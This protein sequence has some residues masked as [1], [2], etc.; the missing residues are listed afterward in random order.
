MLPRGAGRALLAVVLLSLPCARAAADTVAPSDLDA[1]LRVRDQLLLRR[2]KGRVRPQVAGPGEAPP[3]AASF[4]VAAGTLRTEEG[5]LNDPYTG[6]DVLRGRVVFEPGPACPACRSL[7][8]VQVARVEA[9]LGRDLDWTSGQENRNL[10]RTR[11]D[12][13]RGVVEGWFVDHDALRC[14]PGAPCSP[15]FRD[16]WPNPDESADGASAPPPAT[17]ASLVDYPF[18]WQSFERISLESCVRCADTGRFLG[19]VQWGAT[20]PTT[21]ERVLRPTSADEEPSPTFRAALRLFE[22]FYPAARP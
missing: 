22:D 13:A 10:L 2:L 17:P 12:D 4:P 20:W 5:W 11:R 14:A 16:S 6:E 8:V 1:S 18:G 21:G 15:Y 19:C 9:R 3:L 7:R